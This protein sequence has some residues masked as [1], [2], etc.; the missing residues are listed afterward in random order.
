MHKEELKM[1]PPWFTYY[2][3]LVAL[4]GG[5]P[6]I[7]ISFDEE[8]NSIKILVDGQDKAEAIDYLLPDEKEFGNV[9]VTISV[10]PSNRLLSRA[11]IIRK[12]F[13]GN[14]A[15]SYSAT[16]TG[17]YNNPITYVVFKPEVVQYWNDSLA[18]IN[19]KVSTLYENIADK[20]IGG[21]EGIFFCT[22]D[23]VKKD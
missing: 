7:K 10:V 18:D 8:N 12:A 13:A 2:R 11:E 5:D 17:V 3:E 23:V 16:A 22:D 6:D 21:D 15:Y 1:S 14:P 19:G 4:F 20:I 9:K